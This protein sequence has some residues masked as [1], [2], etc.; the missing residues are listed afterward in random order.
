MR[1][2]KKESS[3]WFSYLTNR[4]FSKLKHLFKEDI[5]KTDRNC[6]VSNIFS[7]QLVLYFFPFL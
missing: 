3:Q 1:I 2:I 7:I 4:Y 6:I 5:N